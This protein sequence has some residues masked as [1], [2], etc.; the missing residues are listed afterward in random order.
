MFRYALKG[1]TVHEACSGQQALDLLES[2]GYDLAIIDLELPD[3][4]GLLIVENIRQK[5]LQTLIVI[6]TA[7]NSSSMLKRAC[8]AGAH[9]FIS[10]PFQIDQ[11]AALIQK[12]DKETLLRHPVMLVW[13]T[14]GNLQPYDCSP[15]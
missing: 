13:D 1:F 3:F 15:A 7:D 6:C 8:Q 5:L 14:Y 11:L 10:K 2:G 4:N 12:L 9:V